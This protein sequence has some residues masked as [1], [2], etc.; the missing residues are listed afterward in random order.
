[1]NL[2]LSYSLMDFGL[3]LVTCAFV[4]KGNSEMRNKNITI[5]IV[6]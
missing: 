4:D 2:L 3:E 6:L 5:M 1:M